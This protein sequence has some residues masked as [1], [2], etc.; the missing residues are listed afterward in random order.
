MIKLHSLLLT[1]ALFQLVFKH[2]SATYMSL[3]SVVAALVLAFIS[4]TMGIEPRGFC[5]MVQSAQSH[6][7]I[8]ALD[9]YPLRLNFNGDS[10]EVRV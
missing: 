9:H 10:M 3:I 5:K 1:A 8:L 7:S 2:I 4:R 6:F